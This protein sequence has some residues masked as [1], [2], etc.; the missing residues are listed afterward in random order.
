MSILLMSYQYHISNKMTQNAKKTKAK[1]LGIFRKYYTTVS[2]TLNT[3]EKTSSKTHELLKMD[4]I[5]EKKTF[6]R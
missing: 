4:E 1:N 2:T 5:S 3:R 6:Q